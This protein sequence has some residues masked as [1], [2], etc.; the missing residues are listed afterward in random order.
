[1]FP[2]TDTD[3][4]WKGVYALNWDTPEATRIQS[5]IEASSR[6]YFTDDEYLDYSVTL[7]PENIKKI[8]KYNKD[9]N[10][11]SLFSTKGYTNNTLYAC[12]NPDE[13]DGLL[14][15]CKSTFVNSIKNGEFGFKFNTV[16]GND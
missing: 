10:T 2:G 8:K 3:P 7:T 11:R 1:M 4:D 16:G 9:N 6:L 12:S 15:N 5:Q 14:L 13:N